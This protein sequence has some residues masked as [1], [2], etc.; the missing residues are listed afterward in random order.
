MFE[1]AFLLNIRRFWLFKMQNK[2]LILDN[3]K[4]SLRNQLANELLITLSLP[5]FVLPYP[6]LLSIL[7]Q[8]TTSLHLES[9]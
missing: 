5:K 4:P 1:L 7:I 9:L 2:N 3:F 8:K 6:L